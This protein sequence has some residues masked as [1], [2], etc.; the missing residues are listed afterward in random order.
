MQVSSL[1]FS[2]FPPPSH[3]PNN[4]RSY[5][6]HDAGG[7]D[8][9]QQQQQKNI[10][11]SVL[12]LRIGKWREVKSLWAGLQPALRCQRGSARGYCPCALTL[13]RSAISVVPED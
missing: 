10:S 8:S 9:I 13:C 7:V 5:C 6:G 12:L 11:D 3:P 1:S 2:P 4:K